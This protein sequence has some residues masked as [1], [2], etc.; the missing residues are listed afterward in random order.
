MAKERNWGELKDTTKGTNKNAI[1]PIS[2]GKINTYPVR[3]S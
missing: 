1:N 3:L 2:H